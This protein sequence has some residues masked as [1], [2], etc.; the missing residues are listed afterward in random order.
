MDF[1]MISIS[2]QCGLLQLPRSTS[3]YQPAA[4]NPRSLGLMRFL[5]EEFTQPFYGMARIWL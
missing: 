4:E 2:G 3:Y 5:D 1:G